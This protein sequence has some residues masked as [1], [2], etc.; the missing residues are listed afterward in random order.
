MQNPELK[1][2]ED[3]SHTLYV[4][5]IDECY[6]STHGAI[7]ESK[8][9]FINAAFLQCNKNEINVLEIGFGTGLN[10]FLTLLEAEKQHKTIK[11]TSIE[12]FPLELKKSLSLN[13]PQLIDSSKQNEFE[14]LH[15]SEW[16]TWT[17]IT[18]YFL[19]KKINEDFTKL[20]LQEKFDVIYFD[21][22]SPEKQ[23][24]MWTEEMF[25]KLYLSAEKNAVLTTYCCKGAVKRAMKAAGFNTEKIPGP[26]GKR[27]ILRAR[28][29][30]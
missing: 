16:N 17:E 30:L 10:A 18:S 14:R 28:V 4:S 5:E 19:L 12:L 13:Y 9:I 23:P 3:G 29:V 27:E 7:Q 6:H 25:K 8:H 11:Y 2:T 26:I 15:T 20:I 21:A 1:I 24:E 22:F